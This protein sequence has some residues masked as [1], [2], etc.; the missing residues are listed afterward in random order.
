[1][2]MA[3]PPAHIWAHPDRAPYIGTF[4]E[5]VALL[6]LPQ[7]PA[8]LRCHDREIAQGERF[9]AM[10]FGLD[11]VEYDVV[12]DTAAWPVAASRTI[13][14]CMYLAGGAEYHLLRPWVCGNWAVEIFP[15]GA[16]PVSPQPPVDSGPLY[17]APAVGDVGWPGGGWAFGWAGGYGL[18]AIPAA[19][20]AP[21]AEWPT[22]QPMR[23]DDFPSGG[24]GSGAGGRVAAPEP[25]GMLA[26]ALG[27]FAVLAGLRRLSRS[28]VYG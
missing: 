18:P 23:I 10:T 5:A 16:P 15:L 21:P 12:A 6:H 17:T 27:M 19:F 2:I 24:G 4:G 28:P 26:T 22:G 7:P 9:A 3:T 1:M 14:D 13:A 11:R 8:G 20:A 25:P